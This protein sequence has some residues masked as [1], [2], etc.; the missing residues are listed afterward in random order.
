[1]S[2]YPSTYSYVHPSVDFSKYKLQFL[3]VNHKIL[4]AK[5]KRVTKI[6]S[7]SSFDFWNYQ[8][9][10]W[11]PIKD[12]IESKI[13]SIK[14]SKVSKTSPR[15]YS[16]SWYFLLSYKIFLV[17]S[18]DKYPTVQ[19]VLAGVYKSMRSRKMA[20]WLCWLL[21]LTEAQEEAQQTVPANSYQVP[22]IAVHCLLLIKQTK[23]QTSSLLEQ[24]TVWVID[25][26]PREVL[27]LVGFLFT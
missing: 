16:C 26:E 9:S 18:R 24:A 5:V 19:K 1:M 11:G 12:I 21:L 15:K 7:E 2:V 4:I 27:K 14:L 3:L 10:R 25:F 20:V 6:H 22:V 8:G 13:L 23:H 17:E